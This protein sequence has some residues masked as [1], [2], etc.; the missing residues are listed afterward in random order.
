MSYEFRHVLAFQECSDSTWVIF[1]AYPW[2]VFYK[3]FHYVNKF[4]M[5]EGSCIAHLSNILLLYVF[6]NIENS[7]AALIFSLTYVFFFSLKI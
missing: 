6:V 3:K 1:S 2:E 7:A 5:Q 4:L